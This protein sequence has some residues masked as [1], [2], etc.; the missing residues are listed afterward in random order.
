MAPARCCA[1]LNIGKY[2]RTQLFVLTLGHSWKSVRLLVFRSNSQVWAELHENAFR[3]LGG[4]CGR[5]PDARPSQESLRKT[6][7]IRRHRDVP[8]EPAQRVAPPERGVF[9]KYWPI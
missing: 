7:P 5:Y 2:R 4:A 9:R 6:A 8:G 3:R 1:T